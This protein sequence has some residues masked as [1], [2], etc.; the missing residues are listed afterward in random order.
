[1]Y[2]KRMSG[3]ANEMFVGSIE[4]V[5]VNFTVKESKYIYQ[6]GVICVLF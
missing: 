4:A 2:E 6:V 3:D 5:T 1:M